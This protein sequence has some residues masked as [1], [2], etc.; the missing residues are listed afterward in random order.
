MAKS[1][2]EAVSGQRTQSLGLLGAIWGRFADISWSQR[3][4]EGSL[5]WGSEAAC[6]VLA[7]F[8]F[9]WPFWTDCGVV[10]GK[11]RLQKVAEP[12]NQSM[13][14]FGTRLGSCLFFQN[15]TSWPRIHDRRPL[16]RT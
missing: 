14:E 10:L 7:P 15:L 8:P 2:F 1:W 16:E 6:G 13:S 9:F 4:L 11:K 5:T 3:A 12:C